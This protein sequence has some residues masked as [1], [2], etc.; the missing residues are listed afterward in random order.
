MINLSAT[1]HCTEDWSIFEN[2]TLQ[3]GKLMTAGGSLRIV[4]RGE[5]II[6]L[7][8]GSTA[9]LG[10]V[11]FVP[12]IG[13]NLLST[14]AL[15]ANG[16]ENHQLIKG[17]DFYQEGENVAKGSH[18]GKTSYLTWVRNENALFNE[19]ARRIS[20][21]TRKN[22]RRKARPVKPVKPTKKQA[23]KINF[24][25]GKRLAKLAK[26]VDL[27][28]FH[29]R[30]GYVKKGTLKHVQKAVK[31]IKIQDEL[32]EDCEVCTCAQRTK[33]QSHEAVE[34]ASKLAERLHIDF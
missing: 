32:P 12:G 19:S 17:V 25:N 31:D 22:R 9:R 34:P 11:L 14:Q 18:E 7:P 3:T 24:E 1:A 21:D 23:R 27:E 4:G 8:N 13:T 30:L 16:V 15:L 29:R 33:V 28:L 26:K 2:L 20:E 5:A 6:T 10:D